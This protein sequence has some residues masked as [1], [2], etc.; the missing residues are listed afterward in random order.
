MAGEKNVR[1]WSV[2]NG[3]NVTTIDAFSI[4]MA[5]AIKSIS[6]VEG[7]LWCGRTD[8]SV[9]VFDTASANA[10]AH[11]KLHKGL[12]GA[13]AP[14]H[15]T[16]W[17]TCGSEVAV[18]NHAGT[19]QSR[20]SLPPGPEPAAGSFLAK[21]RLHTVY[22]SEESPVV[23]VLANGT[24]IVLPV[25]WNNRSAAERTPSYVEL[26]GKPIEG[27]HATSLC[28]VPGG[29]TE[30]GVDQV[31]V[32][33]SGGVGGWQQ[34]RGGERLRLFS[35]AG[36]N[37]HQGVQM[38]AGISCLDIRRDKVW[39]GLEDGSVSLVSPQSQ[40]ALL[41]WKAHQ[42]PIQALRILGD[43]AAYTCSETGKIRLWDSSQAATMA[44][45][46]SPS[47]PRTAQNKEVDELGDLLGLSWGGGPQDTPTSAAGTANQ[48]AQKQVGKAAK[49]DPEP[50]AAPHPDEVDAVMERMKDMEVGDLELMHLP[51]LPYPL[52][53]PPTLSVAPHHLCIE[54]SGC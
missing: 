31:W 19:V 36:E 24:P 30:S 34:D 13:V 3:T 7:R 29:V 6:V 22:A 18:L 17:V 38:P 33:R 41:V 23:W 20:F 54:W 46:R 50:A 2:D 5:G 42:T 26:G 1:E 53:T 4:G 45:S 51:P 37:L 12:I 8:G 40:A 9:T 48:F 27:S 39:C 44:G 16:V 32:G 47:A 28:Y 14:V 15:S 11:L 49:G 21:S 10:V 35:A 43:R 52:S 25:S